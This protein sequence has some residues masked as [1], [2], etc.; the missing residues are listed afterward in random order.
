MAQVASV[1]NVDSNPRTPEHVAEGIKNID[2]PKPQAKRVWASVKN[3]A[4]VVIDQ[5]LDEGQRRDPRHCRE[6]VVLLDGQEYQRDVIETSLAERGHTATIILDL[7]HVIEYLWKAS[8]DF[9]HEASTDCEAWVDHY[10]LMIL[11]GKAKLAAGGMRRS[12][13]LQRLKERSNLDKCANYI[14]NNAPYMNYKQYLSQGMP[15]AT[16]VIEGA[17]RYLVKDRMDITGARWSLEGAEAI[18]KLRSI[19]ASGDW[20]EYWQFHEDAEYKRNHKV[21]Y[22]KSQ[23]LGSPKLKLVKA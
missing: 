11:Q 7:I 16:G 9:Y 17:C 18:L 21:H 10:L 12:A 5:M 19:R 22:A 14:H 6:W 23:Y 8:R 20:A 3:D 4:S 15:I 1:Y 2:P 13:T